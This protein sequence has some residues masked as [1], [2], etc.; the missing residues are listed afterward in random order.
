M[1]KTQSYYMISLRYTL[2]PSNEDARLIS[3]GMSRST[4]KMEYVM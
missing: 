4:I 1:R 3:Y 2:S